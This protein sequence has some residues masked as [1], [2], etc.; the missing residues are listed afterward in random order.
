M[1]HWGKAGTKN[2]FQTLP[3]GLISALGQGIEPSICMGIPAVERLAP[4]CFE[5]E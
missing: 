5:P 3:A 4:P 1:Q 2:G